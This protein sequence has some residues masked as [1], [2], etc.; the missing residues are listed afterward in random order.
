MVHENTD[1]QSYSYIEVYFWPIH[2]G[3][4]ED[5]DLQIRQEMYG[6]IKNDPIST[7][8]ILFQPVTEQLINEHANRTQQK[9]ADV[10]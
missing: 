4:Y 9:M 1:N 7:H 10:K 5:E 6:L 8:L 2:D 3:Y